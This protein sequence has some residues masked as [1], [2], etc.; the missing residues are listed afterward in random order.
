MYYIYIYI[1]DKMYFIN[2]D[3]SQK[4]FVYQPTLD[5]LKLPKKKVLIK[6]LVGNQSE[7]ILLTKLKS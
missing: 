4:M 2:D 3:V 1:L 5:T 6:I 7:F